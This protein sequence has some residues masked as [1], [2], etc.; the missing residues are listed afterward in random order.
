[1]SP[2]RPLLLSL[3][4]GAAA[5]GA[6]PLR[7]QDSAL[8]HPLTLGDAVRLAARLNAQAEQAR[9]RADAAKARVTQRRS[10]I[11][12]QL[13]ATAI[14]GGRTYNSATFGLPLPGFDPNGQI[15]GPVN[16]FD[17]RAHAALSLVNLASYE[18]ISAASDAYGASSAD[19]ANVG[20]AAGQLAGIAYLRLQR[21]I[22]LVNARIADS[23]LADSLLA[24]ARDQLASG[25]GVAID[26][27]RAQVQLSSVRAQLISQRADRDHSRLEFLRVVNLPLGTTFT[28][29][30]SLEGLAPDQALPSESA[31]VATALRMRP[32][33][34]A[35][36]L[37]LQAARTTVKSVQMERVPSLGVAADYGWSALNGGSYLPTYTWG[38]QF[39]LPIFDGLRREARIEEDQAAVQEAMSR[40]QAIYQQ[41]SIEVRQ[42]L[43]DAIAAREQLVVA[44]ER[45]ALSTLEVAQARERFMAGV[46]G[47]LDVIQASSNLNTSRSQLIEALANFQAARL[48][49]AR[50][51]GV[52]LSIP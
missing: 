2:L 1:M 20:D 5:L 28:L 26:V 7:A 29:A 15:I 17:A 50:A 31:A 8:A 25:V 18:R 10:E 19:A 47:N 49:F 14:E 27:T 6:P 32:D 4:L 36:E 12:P 46:A 51:E 9:D 37:Q 45:L 52:I 33:L 34:R 48:A 3:A 38:I 42:A 13:D 39:S 43:V 23:L 22:A 21:A 30:D 35:A 11:L 16:T 44:R 40:R 24:I 41:A